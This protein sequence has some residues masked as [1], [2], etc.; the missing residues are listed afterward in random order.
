MECMFDYT[1]CVEGR[2]GSDLSDEGLEEELCRQAAHMAVA[3]CHFVL[4][5]AE[6]DRRGTWCGPGLLSM[7]HWLS[8]RCGTSLATAREQVRVGRALQH[9]PSL[10]RAFAS[11]EL[12][13]SKARAISRVATPEDEDAL[14][15]IARQTTASQLELVVR[16]YRKATPQEGAD[17]L[18]RHQSRR[19]FRTWTEDDGM[20]VFQARL[21]PEDAEV[22]L[23]AVEAAR[24]AAWRARQPAPGDSSGADVVTGADV[25]AERSSGGA[26]APEQDDWELSRADAFV[27]VCEAAVN[28]GMAPGEGG[29][30]AV[31]VLAHVDDHVLRA[32][33]SAGCCSLE[34]VGAVP[35]HTLRRL[36]CSAT[37]HQLVYRDDGTVVPGARSRTVPRPM[38]RA[39][40]ARDRGC[41]FPGCTQRRFVDVHH[42][43]YWSEGGPTVPAN[44]ACLCR[45]HHRLV[46]EGGFRL[47]MDSSCHVRAWGPDGTEVQP[48]PVPL[49]PTGPGLAD[50]HKA[51]G[52]EVDGLTMS[53]GGE[54]MDLG[55]VLDALGAGWE[56]AATS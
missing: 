36:A 24:E 45:R 28:A 54:R 4:L 18:R 37:V 47:E 11:G 7:A 38:R 3:E 27:Q 8:W 55:A 50:Q 41:R 17:A 21:S 16:E 39:V 31:A 12:S 13:Y 49:A 22:V 1:A 23:G 44:L 25:S 43:R 9:L 6:M 2:A 40:L 30:T 29:G 15:E 5:V 35:A 19:Y 48:A 20:V 56:A 34:G 26:D 46:H 42:V 52:L 51:A 53:Y 33:E 14:V 32:P 10:R